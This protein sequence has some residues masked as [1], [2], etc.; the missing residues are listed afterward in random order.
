MR[1]Q[2]RQR[3]PRKPS[4][5]ITLALKDLKAVKKLKGYQINMDENWHTYYHSE[6]CSI[7]LAGAVMTNSLLI[8]RTETIEPVDCSERIENI[9]YSLDHF[10]LGMC[11]NAFYN[12]GL[13]PNEGTPYNRVITRYDFSSVKFVE[14]MTK[15]SSDL[16]EGGY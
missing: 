10:R 3:F 2:P 4:A 6:V 12:M 1:K 8:D 5:L 14:D 9:L 7:C 16:K 13:D 11:S 15:L